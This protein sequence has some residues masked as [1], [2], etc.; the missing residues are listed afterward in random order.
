[1]IVKFYTGSGWAFHECI[2]VTT[3]DKW[4]KTAEIGE[5]GSYIYNAN[6]LS[7]LKEIILTLPDGKIEQIFYG[8]QA[9]LTNN[10]GD[11]ICSL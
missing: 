4:A 3:F 11:T 10:R 1:M 8:H 2:K 7:E 5:V 9:Y 6:E